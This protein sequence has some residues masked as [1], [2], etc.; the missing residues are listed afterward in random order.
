MA[1]AFDGCSHFALE[2]HRVARDAAGQEVAFLVDEVYS[3][4][5]IFVVDVFD[6]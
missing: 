3:K 4:N 2:L 1:S 5:Y 6:I